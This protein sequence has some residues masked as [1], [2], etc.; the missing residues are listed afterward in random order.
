MGGVLPLVADRI[1]LF[2]AVIARDRTSG[3]AATRELFS[4]LWYDLAGTP[5]PCQVP[6]L[7]AAFG[8]SKVLYGS[9]FRFTPEPALAAQISAVLAD[10]GSG[11]VGWKELTYRNAQRLFCR[12]AAR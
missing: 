1:D 2:R 7:V 6:A 11:G 9:D 3:G 5:F 12:L 4:G 8:D 10:A